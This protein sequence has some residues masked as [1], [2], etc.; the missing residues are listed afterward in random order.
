MKIDEHQALELAKKFALDAYQD[1]DCPLNLQDINIKLS[2]GTGRGL[3][4]PHWTV[5]ISTTI[6]NPAVAVRDPD[7]VI[8]L[9][10]AET[11]D[12]QW[13]PIM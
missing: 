2:Q 8:V 11:G 9:V 7:H 13:L 4:N 6:D 12:T 1:L 3:S 5:T 10:D